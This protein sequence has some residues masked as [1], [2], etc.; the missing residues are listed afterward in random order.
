MDYRVIKENDL[1]LMT[2]KTGDIPAGNEAGHGLYTKD[3]RF[4]SGLEIRINGKKP[5]LLS[6]SAGTNYIATIRM[7]NPH[8]ES[9]GQLILWRES[10]ELERQRFIYE[11][12]LYET[13]AFTNFYPK[14]VA[15]DFTA[16]FE[17]D[18]A[19]MFVVRG[20]QNGTFGEA[21]PDVME[22]QKLV[23][24]Y[25]GTDGVERQTHICWDRKE[26]VVQEDSTIAFNF[27]LA[28]KERQS[29]TFFIAPYIDGKGSEQ[30]SAQ[31]AIEMLKASYQEWDHNTTSI[32][33]NLPLFNHLY[34]RGLQ[35]LRVLLTDLG[36][37]RFPVAG[38]PW[39]AVPFGRDSLIAALQMLPAAPNVAKGT[40]LTMASYQGTK[41][42]VWRDEEPGKIMHEIRYGELALTNQIPFTPYY[43]TIDAT[44]LFLLLAA[45]YV[46][47]TGDTALI[48]QLMPNIEQALHWIDNYGD[49][50]GDRFVEY[51]QKSSKGI[52]NQGWKD[53][54]DSVVHSNGNY[55]K[56]PIAL[57]EVQGYVYH[58]KMKLSP[59][60][61]QLGK[62]SMADE[63]ESSAED[64]RQRFESSF[65]ME[66]EGFYAIALDA[67]KKQVQSVTTNPGH[68]LMSGMLQ[69]D[70]AE[71]VVRRLVA[72]DMFS[73]Y[74]IR[75]MSTESSGYNPMSYHDGSIWPHDN[76]LVLLG[77][78]RSGFKAETMQ[79]IEGLM[80][81]SESFEYHR[82]PELYCGYD[83]SIGEPVPYPVACS[84]Q[85]WAAGTPLVFLQTMLGIEPDTLGG[86]IRFNPVLPSG[87]TELTVRN[88]TVAQGK[89]SLHIL[90]NPQTQT[91]VVN[92]LHNTTGLQ[93]IQH[94]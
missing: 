4:L 65:W 1:F 25:K 14:P 7:T 58:A 52:A 80:K 5:I 38:L 91:A 92:V 35:D 27:E 23:K 77:M 11:G 84:P 21:L 15:F 63:L 59:I 73:G 16:Q 39:Y 82:L 57:A 60:L 48:E 40:L 61:R 71:S 8:M 62:E 46:Q 45:E 13:I 32:E 49:A 79:V 56:A 24:R 67:D 69:P 31:Q 2:D 19:D 47:W 36:H 6:S 85:A 30:V 68:V 83:D 17:S 78:S 81:A 22:H 34:D 43:G 12:A 44:P 28:P 33:S 94:S 76:S 87:M 75:T 3:T 50:D 51:Y 93:V 37:G 74:G 88:M 20:F 29:V 70:R 41:E 42:D 9:D 66:E 72:P 26:T 10:V 53:S 86:T 64:L 54:G 55:A 18:F 89:L 90:F